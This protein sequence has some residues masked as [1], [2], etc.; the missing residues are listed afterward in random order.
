MSKN[1]GHDIRGDRSIG[2]QDGKKSRHVGG[3]HACTLCHTS[4][5]VLNTWRRRKLKGSRHELRESICGT[6]SFCTFKPVLMRTTSLANSCGD[7]VENLLNWQPGLIV[8][9]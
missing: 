8:S 4:N 9:H 6:D 1:I 5:A 2:S 3:N 7:L